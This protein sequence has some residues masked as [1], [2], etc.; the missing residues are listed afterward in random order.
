MSKKVSLKKISTVFLATVLVVGTIFS[1]F[2]SLI[3]GITQAE[4]GYGMDNNYEQ[5]YGNDNY[6]SKDNSAILKKIKCNNININNNGIN[7]NQHSQDG[8]TPEGLPALVNKNDFT[9]DEDE[10]AWHRNLS[11]ETGMNGGVD[12]NVI[13]TIC[14]NDNINQV[15]PETTTK[16][17]TQPPT[18]PETCEECFLQNLDGIDIVGILPINVGG[19]GQTFDTREELCNFLKILRT[20]QDKI[21]MYNLLAGIMI[22][23]PTI[24]DEEAEAVLDCL[25][26][27]GLVILP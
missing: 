19:G 9:E 2:P 26:R 27:L 7:V 6:K 12:K 5:S 25:E 20:E 21:F 17:P 23:T 16:P 22:N 18:E 13:T 8:I 10:N 14:T 1:L 4:P 24:D 15:V 3:I 11:G